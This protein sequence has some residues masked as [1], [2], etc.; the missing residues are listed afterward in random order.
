[1]PRLLEGRYVMV[2]ACNTQH[3]GARIRIATRAR[4][5]DGCST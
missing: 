1:V 4:L 2:L 5:D 3:T